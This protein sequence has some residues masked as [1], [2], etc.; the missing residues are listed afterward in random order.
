MRKAWFYLLVD[1]PPADELRVDAPP[2]LLIEEDALLREGDDELR[3]EDALLGA[4]ERADDA[5]GREGLA[6]DLA[7]LL[8]DEERIA[9]VL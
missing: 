8:A 6:D 4:A 3:I 1:A 5:A 2:E 7:V 9:P